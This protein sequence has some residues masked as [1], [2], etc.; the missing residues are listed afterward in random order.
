[1]NKIRRIIFKLHVNQDVKEIKEVIKCKLEKILSIKYPK[2]TKLCFCGSEKYWKI[3]ENTI[4]TFEIYDEEGVYIEPLVSML[5][6]QIYRN[7]HIW[8]V[9]KDIEREV[10]WSKN[11]HGGVLFHEDVVWAHMYENKGMAEES[12]DDI[13]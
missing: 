4:Y 11:T 1:M 8:H 13:V 5:H 7:Y 10:I 9:D 12:L 6:V 3:P 2:S